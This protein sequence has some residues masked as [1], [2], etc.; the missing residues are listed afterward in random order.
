MEFLG[1]ISFERITGGIISG[2]TKM[3]K[4]VQAN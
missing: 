2:V 4:R 1:L 3:D